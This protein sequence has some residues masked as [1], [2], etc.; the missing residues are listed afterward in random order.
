MD[1]GLLPTEAWCKALSYVVRSHSLPQLCPISRFFRELAGKLLSWEGATVFVR[2]SELEEEDGRPRFDP[3]IPH[4]SLCAQ[5]FADFKDAHVGAKRRAARRCLSL[6]GQHCTEA[7][8]LFLRNWC[9]MERDGLGVLRGSFPSLRHLELSAC[10]FLSYANCTL[11]FAA[12]P[13]ILSLRA[14]FAPRATAT[15]AF[16]AA[17]PL[18]LKALGF[19][20]FGSDGDQLLASMLSRCPLEHLWLA[21]TAG[22]S[23]AIATVLAAAPTP[24]K[25]LSLP[26][27]I[28][29]LG[30]RGASLAEDEAIVALARACPHLEL[31]CCWG[32]GLGLV[33]LE[34]F[35]CLPCASGLSYRVIL[36]RRGSMAVQA[37]NGALWAPYSQ[38]DGELLAEEI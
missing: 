34:E 2:A 7:T 27:T 16:V 19:L 38:S 3:L 15:P 35:E 25:T 36:R 37:A 22:F 10:D 30:A 8:G 6:L 12:H 9:L 28:G 23:P 33:Q 14:T 1:I 18:G 17:A 31:L 24:L 11:I 5:I 29:T 32:E 13:A 4:W 26:E 21:R 20:N